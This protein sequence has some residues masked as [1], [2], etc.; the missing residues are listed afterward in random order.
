M[1]FFLSVTSY[2]PPLGKVG[3][4]PCVFYLVHGFAMG[5]GRTNSTSYCRTFLRGVHHPSAKN[6]ND[7]REGDEGTFECSS[8]TMLPL[9]YERTTFVLRNP[10]P[11][12]PSPLSLTYS[13][14]RNPLTAPLSPQ[15][16]PPAIPPGDGFF[17]RKK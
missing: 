2:Y 4:N 1:L 6:E 10:P 16:F 12:S 5:K 8:F 17:R 13:A 14:L 9:W 3:P 7:E 11:Y 15:R